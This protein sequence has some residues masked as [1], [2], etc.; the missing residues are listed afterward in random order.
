MDVSV[1]D[2][3]KDEFYLIVKSFIDGQ[4]TEYA[5][6]QPEKVSIKLKPTFRT[7]FLTFKRKDDSLWELEVTIDIIN[8]ILYF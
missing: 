5:N 8:F 3:E 7:Y 6:R 4:T 1:G 2:L